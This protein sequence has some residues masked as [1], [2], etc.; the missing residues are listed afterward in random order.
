MDLKAQILER[1]NFES[2][3]R[4][5]LP[6]LTNGRGDEVQSLCPFH[7]DSAPSLSVNL[8]SGVFYCHGCQAKG[9]VFTFYQKRHDCD[10]KGALAA[11]A[12]FAGVEQPQRSTRKPKPKGKIVATYDYLGLNG[13]MGFQV[14]RI[15]PGK[16]E[17]KKDFLQRRPDGKGGWIWN[18][19]GVEIIPYRLPELIKA[20]TVFIPEGEKDCDN[21][22]KLGVAATCNPMGAGKWRPS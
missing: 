12:Q 19:E 7:E 1:L 20:E 11:L 21:L 17:K 14:C 18:L 22:R 3:Y 15:E 10:F 8:K 16:N 9:D 13:K 6:G 4:Q 5:E 2:F